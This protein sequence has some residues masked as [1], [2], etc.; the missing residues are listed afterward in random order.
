MTR[1]RK[2]HDQEGRASI[3]YNGKEIVKGCFLNWEKN[4][5]VLNNSKTVSEEHIQLG[6]FGQ[7]FFYEAFLIF[8]SQSI[9]LSL[10]SDNLLFCIFAL[11]DKRVGKRLGL[12][13]TIKVESDTIK[14]FYYIRAQAE[15]IL[16]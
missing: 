15:N 5:F 8:D 4:R 14:E 12:K 9:E 11:L 3:R 13:D 1:Y 6:A 7:Q 16:Y 2:S 10:L